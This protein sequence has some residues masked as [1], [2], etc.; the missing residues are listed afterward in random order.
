MIT[1]FH[2]F[3]VILTVKF[4]FA[5]ASGRDKPHEWY[6]YL[7]A[8]ILMA[9]VAWTFAGWLVEPVNLILDALAG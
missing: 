6:V 1:Q 4:M 3:A 5:R 2:I 7:L 9:I 8:I